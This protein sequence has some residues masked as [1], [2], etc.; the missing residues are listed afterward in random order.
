M[1]LPVGLQILGPIL[2]E[3]KCLMVG[4]ILEWALRAKIAS[5]KPLIF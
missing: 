3:E 2:W 5:K 4:H 1:S